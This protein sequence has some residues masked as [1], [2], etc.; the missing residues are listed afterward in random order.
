MRIP[1]WTLATIVPLLLMPTSPARAQ[2]AEVRAGW[3]ET[4]DGVRLRYDAVGTGSDVVLIP[5]GFA[6]REDLQ[7]LAREDRTLVFY[8]SRNRGRSDTVEDSTKITVQGDMLDIEAVRKEFGVEQVS[9]VG[10]SVY[11]MLTALYATEHPQGVRRL[12]RNASYVGGR[13]WAALFPRD[14]SS[15]SRTRRT[16]C[17][18]TTPSASWV[19][20]TRFWAASGRKGPKTFRSAP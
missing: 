4:A 16:T 14:G 17:G 5:H 20:S 7:R 18:W 10:Y 19:R 11:G 12:A 15:R 1:L 9:L 3:V 6:L 8:D 13:E 2:D